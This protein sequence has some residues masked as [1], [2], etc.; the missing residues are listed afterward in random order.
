MRAAESLIPDP[1]GVGFA[2]ESAR[3]GGAVDLE[4]R[5]PT[6]KSDLV[7]SASGPAFAGAEARST[8]PTIMTKPTVLVV[9]DD[10]PI[11]RGLVD[12]LKYAGYAVLECDNGRE[13]IGE[14]IESPVG[15]VLLDVMLPE[16]DGF[17]VLAELRRVAPTLPVIMVTARG[18]EEDR[19]RGLTHGADDYVVKPFSARELLARVEAVLRRSPERSSDVRGLRSEDVAIDLERREVVNGQGDVTSLTEREVAILRYLAISRGRAIDRSEL[20]HHVWGINPDGIQT[21]TVDMHIARLREKVEPRANDPEVVLTVRGKG[22][23]LGD[24]VEVDP[25]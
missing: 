17:A 3:T 15:L 18:S 14:A 4:S 21:R 23:K 5:R 9:E 16:M 24:R 19:V 20:L 25:S 22:Y 10:V 2:S 13:A 7:P 8:V 12:A 1:S 6:R 11:R